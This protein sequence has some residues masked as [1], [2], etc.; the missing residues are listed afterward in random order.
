MSL[1]CE[2]IV[3]RQVQD[4]TQLRVTRRQANY[5]LEYAVCSSVESRWLI[6]YLIC[7][8][9]ST[10]VDWC[11]CVAARAG[12]V[13]TFSYLVRTHGASI[14]QGVI[15]CC[16][17]RNRG[18]ATLDEIVREFDLSDQDLQSISVDDGQSLLHLAVTE[19]NPEMIRHLVDTYN[20]DVYE[21]DASE[22]TPLELLL[23]IKEYAE[24]AVEIFSDKEEEDFQHCREVLELIQSNQHVLT[25]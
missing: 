5:M 9:K 11:A 1:L 19:L 12:K 6:D 25:E 22:N 3:K 24:A 20:F 16:M 13:D 21:L 2:F 15:G 23:D 10:W 14:T 8:C 7:E 17:S 4:G 18:V